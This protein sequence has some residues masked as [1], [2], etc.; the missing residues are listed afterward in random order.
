MAQPEWGHYEYQPSFVLAF[1]GCEKKIGEG[2]LAG[3]TKHLLWSQKEYDWLGSGIYF[4]EGDPQRAYEWA[5][6]RE[7]E[8]KIETPFVLGAIVD[9]K[10]CLDLFDRSGLQQIQDANVGLNMLL[11][12]LQQPV[13]KNIGQTPDKAG[14]ALDCATI[15]YLH[16]YR[17]AQEHPAYDSIRGP[18]LEGDRIYVDAGFRLQTHIQICV[19]SEICIKGYFR[20]IKD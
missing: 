16:T 3:N 1:H 18:F 11:T 7:D 20:P 17:N 15:N 10:H 4:W 12:S 9:L 14:R 13:P 2:I 5:V 6:A 19:R 8:G